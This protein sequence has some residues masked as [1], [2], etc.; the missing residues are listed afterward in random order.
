M[1][2][3]RS[4]IFKNNPAFCPAPFTSLVQDTHGRAGPCPYSSGSYPFGEEVPFKD[5]WSHSYATRLR[6][7]HMAGEKSEAC[8]R[9][10]KEEAS[11]FY[12]RRQGEH[13]GVIKYTE[14]D[15]LDGVYRKGPKIMVLRLS[16]H[17]NYACRTCHSLDS[18]LFKSEGDFYTKQY[19]DNTHRYSQKD[20]R[21]EFTAE[22]MEELYSLSECLEHI[23][24]YGGEP[25]LNTTH[26]LFLQ[27]LVDH[28]R[29]A[30]I[31][32][33]YCTNASKAPT[34]VRRKIWN[35]FK[36]V[37][38]YFSLDGID[39]N[40]HYIRWPGDWLNVEK[41]IIE[42]TRKL[43][44]EINAEVVCGVSTTVSIL[45]IFYVI[46]IE[47]RLREYFPE[48]QLS[49]TAV[50]DP[51][52]Y[53]IVNIPERCKLIIADKLQESPLYDKFAGLVGFMFSKK[54]DYKLWDEFVLWTEKKDKY[55][56]VSIQEYLPEFYHIIKPEY[57]ESLG[58]FRA[59][60]R[61]S[62]SPAEASLQLQGLIYN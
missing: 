5:R 40:Y 28:G 58:D 48:D 41:N 43:P 4:K 36:A 39:K 52:Y 19:G 57:Q 51:K 50:H 24:F 38:F 3:F 23:E 55:R 61:A 59:L 45:N 25:M 44:Q 29:A 17:C 30:N 9:C 21:R 62:A 20:E 33:N 35:N 13:D 12:S 49:Y 11:G 1:S 47:K 26:H 56:N 14:Q 31:T 2:Q 27:K 53:S 46:E 60:S 18:S 34:D 15:F 32:L 16:N 42:Y 7:Q 6:E 22:Q 8:M 10:Y 37:R 54:C